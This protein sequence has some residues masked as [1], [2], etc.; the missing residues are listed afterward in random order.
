MAYIQQTEIEAADG[1]LKKIFQDSIKRA[2]RVWNIVKLTG[3]NPRATRAHLGIYG[4]VMKLDTSLSVR[5]RE[6]LAVVV[7]RA[8]D[9]HY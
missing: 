5:E 1:L 8:N 2:G 9:C 7:S 6:T 4:S 3:I